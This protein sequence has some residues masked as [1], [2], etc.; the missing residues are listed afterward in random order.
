MWLVVRIIVRSNNVSMI[1]FIDGLRHG[2]LLLKKF[3]VDNFTRWSLILD[4]LI[5]L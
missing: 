5:Y 1:M 2:L 3:D 4:K